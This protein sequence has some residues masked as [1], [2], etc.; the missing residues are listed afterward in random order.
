MIALHHKIIFY[1]I[2]TTVLLT[3]CTNPSYP[4]TLFSLKA[5][6]EIGVSFINELDYTEELNTYTYRNFYNGGGVGI[7]DFNNDGLKDFYLTGNLVDNHLYINNGDWTFTEIAQKAGVSCPEVWSTGVSIADIN[8]DGLD[9]IYVCKSGPP[10][11]PNRNNELFINNGDLT[12]TESAKKYGLDDLGL[13]TH[14]AFFDMD[15]D[16]DLDCYLLNNSLRS[17]GNYDLIA[18]QREKKDSLGGNK[19]YR[20]DNEVFVDVSDEAGIYTSKIGFGLGVS[21]GDLN[22]DN[23]PDIYVSNDYF[24]KDYLYLN[25]QD[26]TFEESIDQ[27]ITE[28]S[29]SSMGADMA[30]INN[31]GLPEIFV[32]DMLPSTEERLKSKTTFDDWNKSLLQHDQGYGWQF[33][34]NAL[35]LNNGDGT[36]SEIGRYANVSATDWSW[37]ALIFDMDD[38]GHKDIFV[39][40]G[41]YKD[42]TDQDYINFIGDP[43]KIRGMIKNGKE[44]IKSLVDSIPSEPQPNAAFI[45]QRDLSFANEAQKLGLGRP[46]FSNGA[47]FVDIDNDGDLDLIINN[48]NEPPFIYENRREMVYPERHYITLRAIN[49]KTGS[50]LMNTRAHLYMT[51]GS[52]QFQEL[53]PMRSYMSSTDS[54]LHFGI[55]DG[56]DIDSLVVTW[57]D[58]TNLVMHDVPLDTMLTLSHM[59]QNVITKREKG[60]VADPIFSSI[61]LGPDHQISH[62]ENIWS[63]FDRQPLLFEMSSNEGP[64]LCTADYNKDGFLDI[65]VGGSKGS[66]GYLYAGSQSKYTSVPL[67]EAGKISEDTDC[68]F[69][70]FDNDGWVDLYVASGGTEF[71]ASSSALNDRLY[72]NRKGTFVKSE[73]HIAFKKYESTG[74]VASADYDG[75]GDFDLFIGVRQVPFK[76]GLSADGYI[77][78]NE[79]GVFKDVTDVVAPELADLGMITDALWE[80]IDKDGDLDLVVVG[81]WMPICIFENQEGKLSLQKGAEAYSYS[82]LWKCIVSGDIDGDGDIDLIVGN[83]GLNSTLSADRDQSLKLYVNDFDKNGTLDPIFTL[84]KYG[85]DYPVALQP[86]MLKQ[87]PK[88]KSQYIRHAAYSGK[89]VSEIFSVE[90]LSESVFKEVN[91][92]ENIVLLNDGIGNY[93]K[94][95]MPVEAQLSSIYAIAMADI[96]NDEIDEIIYGGN[97]FLAKPQIGSDGASYMGVLDYENEKLIYLPS[98]RTG[99]KE[100]GMIRAI[101]K[102]STNDAN[103]I[104][105]GKNNDEAKIYQYK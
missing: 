16:G 49:E 58:K 105:V 61:D 91:T 63:D 67:D 9:D 24:E 44:V 62:T 42:L 6:E 41:L 60:T 95:S 20:N 53:M 73:K 59:N 3:A 39:A 27:S 82:G 89:E 23:W 72:L 100:T 70:D 40:N 43:S 93:K 31:D 22:N 14:A 4:T 52:I 8:Q 77:F 78:N 76:Y 45:N 54:D 2:L 74:A 68:V 29:L 87:L 46:S 64:C 85:K 84:S 71:P 28:M 57:P 32:T 66:A 15:K 69:K 96:D 65:Y 80:D 30:D 55:S 50:V 88:L 26:G 101:A 35:Q 21:I 90:E 103:Y 1:I 97:Q 25:Q 33:T 86:E 7:G 79:D 37:G 98:S 47:V 83:K 13:S 17:V 104:I 81:E 92:L 18:G 10:G 36:F 5:N 75:D 12:F 94:M 11:G 51:D 48:V 19:L 34:R 56:V 38:D 99:L 102:S